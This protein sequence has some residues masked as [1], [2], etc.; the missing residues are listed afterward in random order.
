MFAIY[1]L[2]NIELDTIRYDR[3]TYL[4]RNNNLTYYD[5]SSVLIDTIEDI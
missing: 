4:R 1:K 5:V 2:S 3:D